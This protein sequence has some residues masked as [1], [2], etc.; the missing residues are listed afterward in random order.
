MLFSFSSWILLNWSTPAVLAANSLIGVVSNC[1]EVFTMTLHYGEEWGAPWLI[2][3]MGQY[4][5]VYNLAVWVA[6]SFAAP[7]D[8]WSCGASL[9]PRQL[10]HGHFSESPSG[11]F[12]HH[13]PTTPYSTFVFSFLNF[14]LTPCHRIVSSLWILLD[15][16]LNSKALKPGSERQCSFRTKQHTFV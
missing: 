13:V 5:L 10:K 4:A 9:Y 6:G 14:L 16:H 8:S 1:P 3:A 15:V 12:P 2:K 11:R 7:S